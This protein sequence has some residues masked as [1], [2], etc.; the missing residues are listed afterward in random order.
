MVVR[1]AARI[2]ALLLPAF[3]AFN[4]SQ[5]FASIV[6]PYTPNS[7]T[8]FLFHLSEPPGS[9]LG[10][11]DVATNSG[12]AG[13]LAYTCTNRTGSVITNPPPVTDML[14]AQAFSNAFVNFG[15]CW[16]NTSTTG[17]GGTNGLVGYD[18]NRNG[19]FDSEG[20][21]TNGLDYFPMTNLN[22]GNGGA[23]PFTLEAMVCPLATNVDEEIFSTDSAQSNRGFQFRINQGGINF[24]PVKTGPS[25]TAI[26]PRTGPNAF[27][28]NTWFH[29][30]ATYDGA[31]VKIYWTAVNSTNIAANLL[32]NVASTAINTNF[33]ACIGPLVIGNNDRGTGEGFVGRIGEVRV[34]SVCLASNQ[35]LFVQTNGVF[36]TNEPQNVIA[37]SGATV[38]FTVGAFADYNPL[39]YQWRT[40]GVAIVN[41]TDGSGA[42]FVGATSPTLTITNAQTSE[43]RWT[44]SCLITN[45]RP[46]PGPDF[47]NTI[48]ATLTL[49]TPKNL[50]WRGTVN[51]NWDNSAAT[52][53]FDTVGLTNAPFTTLDN[54]TFDDTGTGNPVNIPNAVGPGSVT[55]SA[56]ALNYTLSGPGS[57]S[58]PADTSLVTGLT[59][60]NNGVLTIQITNSYTGVTMLNGGI[61]GVSQL[62]NGGTPSSIGAAG[63][64]SS[65]LVF[66]GGQLQYTGPTVSINRGM[67]LNAGGGT[68]AVTNA[69]S[70][71]TVSG[72]IA[73]SGGLT[74]SNNG[75][76]ALS[77][78]NTFA[79]PATVSAGTLQL[80]GSALAYNGATSIGSGATLQMNGGTGAVTPGIGNITDNGTLLSSGTNL[81]GSSI[82]GAGIL[83]NAPGG[84]LILSGTNT[85][86]GIVYNGTFGQT[87][88]I[89]IIS[90]SSDALDG[91]SQVVLDGGNASTLQLFA[92]AGTGTSLSIPSSVALV[93]VTGNGTTNRA[94]ISGNANPC[95]WNG[96]I[97]LRGDGTTNEVISFSANAS[98]FTIN[99][100]VTATLADNFGGQVGFSGNANIAGI[101][102]G[103][104][105]L[106]TNA[107][108][109]CNISS[110]TINSS[111]NSSQVVWVLGGRLM[112]GVD[113]ALP[114]NVPWII[115]SGTNIAV[116]DLAGHN[117]QLAGLTNNSGTGAAIITNSSP[118]LS[119]LT[120]S[121]GVGFYVFSP[122]SSIYGTTHSGNFTNFTGAIGGKLGLTVAGGVLNLKGTNS[123]FGATTIGSGT[124]M[125]N[126]NGSI[127]KSTSIT[128]SANATFDVS[129]LSST[130]TLGSAQ[131]LIG[132][133]ATGTIAGNVNVNAGSSLVLNYDG[134][135]PTLTVTNGTLTCNSSSVV[136]V[137]VPGSLV[138]GTPY[139]LVSASPGGA[140]AGTP[141]SFVAVNGISNTAGSLS[142]SNGQLYL[143]ISSYT[144]KNLLWSGT[145][146]GTWDTSGNTNWFDTGTGLFT[147]FATLDNVTFDDNGVSNLVSVPGTVQPNSITV[148]AN[149]T[150]YTLS[151]P[152]NILGTTGLIKTG[153]NTLTIQT[154]NSYT[155]VT[156]LNGGIVSV[157]QLALG[158]TASALGAA[159]SEPANLVLNGAQ[160]QY[161]GPSVSID[162]GAT[163]NTNG[164]T[165]TVTTA[166]NTLTTSGTIAGSGGL[167]VSGSG[168]FAVSGVNTYNGL[169]MVNAGATLGLI[170]GGTF[171]AGN[172]TNNGTLAFSGAN[173]VGNN[174]S[175][176]GILTNAPG[177]VLTLTGTNTFSGNVDIGLTNSTSSGLN[178]ANSSAL[179][180]TPQ[181]TLYAGGSFVTLSAGVS[182]P[183]NT[184]LVM[185]AVNGAAS[186]SALNGT[187]SGGAWNGPIIFTGDSSGNQQVQF[188]IANASGPLTINGN[189]SNTSSFLG[190]LQIRGVNGIG[191]INGTFSLNTNVVFAINDGSVWTVNSTNNTCGFMN[192]VN[193]RLK[194]GADNALPVN[195][196]L[197][198]GGNNT[199]CTLDLAGHNQLLAGLTNNSAGTGAGIIT[200]SSAVP[201]VLTFSNAPGNFYA[202]AGFSG[203]YTNF[204]GNIK[205]NLALAVVSGTLGLGGA[206]T[207]T[208]TTTITNGTLALTASG[209]IA[210]STNIIIE[211]GATFS[212]SGQSLSSGQTLT[213]VGATGTIGGSLNLG[214]GSSLV[215]NYDTVN[216][217]LTVTS[218]AFNFNGNAATVTV[219]VSGPLT[220]QQPYLLISSSGGGLVSGTPPSSVIV[221][222]LTNA[223]GTYGLFLSISNG[224]LYLI[225]SQSPA[226]LSQFPVTY[227]NLF[228]L[229]AGASPTFSIMA[230]GG[231]PPFEYQWY[232]NGAPVTGATATNFTLTNVQA[233][234]ANLYCVVTNVYGSATSFVWAA[235]VIPGPTNSMGGLASHPATVL[236]NGPAGYWRLNEPD[237]GFFDGNPGALLFDYAGGNNGLYTNVNLGQP[238][239]NTNADPSDTSALFGS[240]PG[241]PTPGS[242]ANSIQGVDVSAP[243]GANGE[244]TVEALVNATNQ[245]T[246]N[247]GIAAKGY[248][249]QEEFTLD[250][251]GPANAFR[252]EVR[253]AAGTAFNANSTVSN[254]NNGRWHHL[255]GVCDQSSGV[256]QLYIDGVLAASTSIPAGS[257]IFNS[258][259]TPM[260]IG[261]RATSATSGFTNQ[262]YGNINDVA[263][264][265]YAFSSNQVAAD[266][267]SVG[268]PPFFAQQSST[269]IILYAGGS[270]AMSVAAVGAQPIGYQWYS[271]NTA[272]TG[273][274]ATNYVLTNAQPPNSVQIY[275][276]VASNSDN[277]TTSVLASVTVL[278][279]PVAPYPATV[280]SN[281]PIGYWRLNEPDDGLGDN[282]A[283]QVCHDYWRGNNGIFTNT[284]LGQPGYTASHTVNTDPT[285]T[286]AEFGLVSIT[287]GDAF[288]IAGVD[289]GSPAS[290][291][292]A[293]TVEA[294]VNGFAQTKDAGI[295]SKGYGGGGEQFDLDTGSDGAPTVHGFRFLVRDASGASHNANSK[296]QPDGNWHHL[297]GVCDEANSNVTL[298]VDGAP[299]ATTAISPGSGILSS[300]RLMLI[301]SRPGNST[302]NN[303]FQ[304]VGNVNDVAVYNYALS[305]SQVAADFFSAGIAPFFTQ[306]P[307]NSITA[308]VGDTLIVPA[309]ASGTPALSYQWYFSTGSPVPN[310]TNATLVVSNVDSA[311]YNGA[312]LYLTVT[313]LYG[314]S[315]ST[316]VSV[317]IIDSAPTIIADIAPT[318]ATL[319]V[320]N[321]LTYSFV[322]NG[323]LPISYQWY[324]NG[325]LLFGKT[326]ST[327]TATAALGANTYSC[328]ASN[329]FNGGSAT[330]SA[331]ATLIGINAPTNPYPAA[332]LSNN[333]IAY[334]RLDE[335]DDGLNDGN[336]GVIA[337]DYVGGHNAA[338]NN[339]ILGLPGYNPSKDP[340]TAAEFGVFS[341]SNSYAGEIDASSFA[342]IDFAKPSGGNAEF[343]V[344]AWVNSTNANQIAGAG[345]VTKGFGSGG[346]QFDLD[347]SGNAFRFFVRDAAG[348]VHGPTST[349]IATVGQW[350]HVVGVWDGANGAAHL[351]VNGVDT[352]DTTGVAP[353][354]GLLAATTT[355]IALPGSALVSIGAR[356][357][358]QAVN[359]YNLQFQGTI[360]EVAIYNLALSSN[361]V[362][363]HYDA[364]TFVVVTPGVLTITNLHN[365]QVQLLWNFSGTLQSATNVTGPYNTVSNATSPYLEPTTNAQ[366]FYR[367]KQ[368]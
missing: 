244:F 341:G 344:E 170:G 305:A 363:A 128:I 258:F 125:L 284:Q 76:L 85:F 303:N 56:N 25:V 277:S 326:N 360:D 357:S 3:F 343:S 105:F 330:G 87:R 114:G 127:A 207:Y 168:V 17:A 362:A 5:S 61:V 156:A 285:E 117:Q 32:T 252:F 162:R 338:Y 8:L 235:S 20:S 65:N 288:G 352:A 202:N 314:T 29:V 291:S 327:Y 348:N 295:V 226:I 77:G 196:P 68:L 320:G 163:L 199:T 212:P 255:V 126:G 195:V 58:N 253:N 307:T 257:G 38:I 177:S 120:Y 67:T 189:I 324:R 219:N 274:T 302:T 316:F 45:S 197:L 116:F 35:M 119:T 271:N 354:V 209:S 241:Y 40:N 169:T 133:G 180:N 72:I 245:Q 44:Y 147:N 299:A 243:N 36:I 75:T 81:I 53:W 86:T 188:A 191:V 118:V 92:P 359:D 31:N 54:V 272:I 155:G 263:V 208:G 186:R 99:G 364:G 367:V 47:T 236:S 206:N 112:P 158:G 201:V 240:F 60:N 248:F 215:V 213:A 187:G 6:G 301:G 192:C 109:L 193:G 227:T 49:R 63:S 289:F 225:L 89:L 308:F 198:L 312:S 318:N 250:T 286:S 135:N 138:T 11:Y 228:T 2:V 96:P 294:W 322:V 178:V 145:V 24:N 298:Y 4:S 247:N 69:G 254:Y 220:P 349:N 266:F 270:A 261:A 237:D 350:F 210:N 230:G 218:G 346:E 154:T 10:G 80:S 93:M 296:I 211:P 39:I 317:S 88:S 203:Y 157:A 249:F 51:S 137:N 185:D 323:S 306:E 251:G 153:T 107:D 131:T 368:Q 148:S 152:G 366:K 102:N 132:L 194:L 101:M 144:P 358:S 140:V 164:G 90:N 300:A 97:T 110:W 139:L 222:G 22:M 269:N 12:T 292:V 347:L 278:P 309:V 204:T 231:V 142:I 161:T 26:I 55:V 246:A 13:G 181:V 111:G 267:N 124:L 260:T 82:S 276:C 83:T 336:P 184:T 43:A 103:H 64:G 262:F 224:G 160:L 62:A 321:S 71:L 100:D 290:T 259:T 337:H 293:F 311:T 171:G 239:Y 70:T 242:D 319:Y 108:F 7:T 84:T 361:Q 179:G 331:V 113:N 190:Q 150:N 34:S 223:P 46:F 234:F 18:Y 146:N 342:T 175:G 313:N 238:G 104:F 143:T 41:G 332:V 214:A 130:F 78:A 159:G 365:S 98:P 42:T 1:S 273:A 122:I 52:N 233:P 265:K 21:G 232:S 304:F 33:G 182:T 129:T 16:T 281:N 264:Y 121:N 310:Q 328:T 37:T 106:N 333:P 166:G 283:G 66:N 221:N 340:D 15:Y 339:T 30:A 50:A 59:K 275:Y 74:V 57:I 256:V 335:S 205:G 351:Y 94:N 176:P 334:W 216:P 165:V 27:V 287:D 183:T 229:Y 136:T 23:S 19:Q 217:T 297:V 353:G 268:F 134:S 28:A 172:V 151:G 173:A 141:P 282:N 345:I 95:T 279:L 167:T 149:N 315:N 174:I 325:T 200:N 48:N 329:A 355:N 356:T 73:G 91:T 14:G 280:L 123:Y 115:G 9:E 79:G